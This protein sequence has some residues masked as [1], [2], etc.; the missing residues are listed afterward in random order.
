MIKS[1][2][3]LNA[4]APPVVH[5]S[6]RV[7]LQSTWIGKTFPKLCFVSLWVYSRFCLF[8]QSAII[9][10]MEG[11]ERVFLLLILWGG[12]PL[13]W[14]SLRLASPGAAPAPAA[15][16]SRDVCRNGLWF[17]CW[18]FLPF[19]LREG[20]ESNGSS[21]RRELLS[22]ARAARRA[23]EDGERLICSFIDS[24]HVNCLFGA[25][26]KKDCTS[27]LSINFKCFKLICSTGH[28]NRSEYGV[29]GVFSFGVVD[30]VF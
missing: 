4:K 25:V 27:S 6:G 13:P 12:A 30:D 23:R 16:E 21:F 5:S 2:H 9:T 3:V 15:A 26:A 20:A 24:I 17:I 14:L 1:G 8:T 22:A 10:Q 29:A 28:W 19:V 11:A 18:A 7:H